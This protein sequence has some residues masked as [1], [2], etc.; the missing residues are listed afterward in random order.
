[1]PYKSNFKIASTINEK[2]EKPSRIIAV[3]KAKAKPIF[4]VKGIVV[5]VCGTATI[6]LSLMYYLEFILGKYKIKLF[7][8]SCNNQKALIRCKCPG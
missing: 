7:R 2:K 6:L 4:S 1:M 8:N 5:L 3:S